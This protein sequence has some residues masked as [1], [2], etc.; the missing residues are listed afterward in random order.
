VI[1]EVG[2]GYVGVWEQNWDDTRWPE[3]LGFSRRLLLEVEEGGYHITD[4]K[5]SHV[6]GWI[7][8]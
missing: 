7:R 6:S 3:G 8:L 5:R 2:E 4:T 1:A